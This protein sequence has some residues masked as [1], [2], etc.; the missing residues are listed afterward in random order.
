MPIEAETTRRCK[1]CAAHGHDMTAVA[2]A[3]ARITKAARAVRFLMIR[4]GRAR[5]A[6]GGMYR[7]DFDF[8]VIS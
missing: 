6:N 4:R 7:L 8:F 2:M 5:K 3:V 1:E